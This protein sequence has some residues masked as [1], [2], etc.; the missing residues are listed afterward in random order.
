VGP[1]VGALIGLLGYP[2]AFLAV[3]VCPAVAVPLVPPVRAE[4]DRL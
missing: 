2:L 1:A 4:H 3:A